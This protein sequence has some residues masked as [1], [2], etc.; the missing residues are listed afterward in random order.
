MFTISHF[1]VGGALI[2]VAKGE[3]NLEELERKIHVELTRTVRLTISSQLIDADRAEM[4]PKM[5]PELTK[6]AVEKYMLGHFFLVEFVSEKEMKLYKAGLSRIVDPVT[7][8]TPFCPKCVCIH[9]SI[10]ED[11]IA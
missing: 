2:D 5:T 11:H 4:I 10:L 6:A 3:A 7:E 9:S 1:V 8:C